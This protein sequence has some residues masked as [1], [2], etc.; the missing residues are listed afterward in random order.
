M[1]L[2]FVGRAG[3]LAAS[4]GLACL[5]STGALAQDESAAED[6]AAPA[7]SAAEE[8]PSSG[9]D[10]PAVQEQEPDAAQET[11]AESGGTDLSTDHEL[12]EITVQAPY[13]APPAQPAPSRTA[14]APAPTPTPVEAD[15]EAETSANAESAWGPV[16]GYVAE[17]TGT[18]IKTDTPLN[19]IP[20]SIT[21]VTEQQIQDQGAT[22]VQQA[23]NYVPGVVAGPYGFDIRGDWAR[24]RG[25]DPVQYLDGMRRI[26]GYYN[27]TRVDPYTL[28][29]IEVLKGPA[30][31]LYGAGSTAGIINL[32]SKR[33]QEESHTEIGVLYGTH[34]FG[35]VQ[36]DS[37]GKITKDG[38]WLYRLVG[39]ARNSDT[40]VD[41]VEYDR[42]VFNPSITWRPDDKTELTVIAN[43]Q[44]DDT[45]SSAN[46]L[47]WEGTVYP[48][49]NGYLPWSTFVSDPDWDQYKTES[50]SIEVLF[51]KELSDV[52]TFRQGL[53]YV[54][55]EVDYRS[56]YPNVYTDPQNP[57]VD[58][59][60][61]SVQRYSYIS[62]PHAQTFTS[63]SNFIA[64][65]NTGAVEHKVLLGVDYTRF[66][67]NSR[68]GSG[69]VATPFDLYDPDY[70][71]P[72]IP[73]I[74]LDLPETGTEQLGF[75][76]Q[77]QIKLGNWIAVLGIRND[78][79]T[80]STEGQPDQDVNATTY[81]AGIMYEFAN[82]LTP[83]FS[84]MQSFDPIFGTNFYGQA[85]DP[86]EGEQYEVGFKYQV[87]GKPIVVNGS[88]YDITQSNLQASDP[89]N[90]FNQIQIG[91]AKFK[92]GE[93]ETIFT[94]NDNLD[95]IA[96]YA[97]TDAEYT[98]GDRAGFRVETV[99]Q[100]QASLWATYRFSAFGVSGFAVG[101]G[102]RYVGT[103]WDGADSLKT[104]SYTL[105]DGMLS[106]D[107]EHWRYQI[108]ATNL[109][110]E[111]YVTTCLA[112]GDCFL[113]E[114]RTVLGN[115]T[116]KF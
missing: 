15:L 37:T 29:R 83:Y 104:P 11:D 74:A 92:G 30:S 107:T 49:P 1:E 58:P 93:I 65:F 106:Y 89:N 47:P 40:Q 31:V 75:Y 34:D 110:D 111:R 98:A 16:D 24:I 51:D 63:D 68:Q 99:P 35:Q 103:S 41:Y 17:R 64:D 113:G 2:R 87:P 116:Y 108:N 42:Y 43:F 25:Q 95:V 105:F 50:A 39:V 78:E 90:P 59:A 5:I 94:L 112:R 44:K 84:Y 86:L 77:D 20:Q 55:A 100:N 97:Y 12:P 33:P 46:F 69:F 56:M 26:Y 85:F 14:S 79:V 6:N 36:G 10:T 7:E 101:G 3:R 61:R 60:R 67:E 38:K 54:D 19:E 81:R 28:E 76:A 109:G 32:I 48:G 53:R 8:N 45:G 57:F 82:G 80:S 72:F 96:G 115:I 62:Q 21:V 18:G 9:T 91:E 88:L 73:P 22:S 52:W 27:N 13:E 4:I 66:K 70:S 71:L 114:G 102:V 23:L